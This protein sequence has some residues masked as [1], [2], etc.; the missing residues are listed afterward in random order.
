MKV[1]VWDKNDHEDKR[2]LQI[3]QKLHPDISQLQ[4]NSLS[5][6]SL[7]S[8]SSTTDESYKLPQYKVGQST[9]IPKYRPNPEDTTLYNPYDQLF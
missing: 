9:V 3:L 2:F 4:Y 5:L 8:Y 7:V 1:R 6:D